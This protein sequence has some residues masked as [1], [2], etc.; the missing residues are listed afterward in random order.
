MLL[1]KASIG[2]KLLLAF[3]AMA[4]IVLMSASVGV[5]SFSYVAQTE[6]NVVNRVIPSMIEA[7]KVSELSARIIS[8]VQALTNSRTE[9]ERQQTGKTLFHQLETLLSH[10]SQLGTDV[11]DTSLLDKLAQD[12]QMIID[13]LA[14]L[15]TVVEGK[16]KHTA[17]IDDQIASMRLLATELE[18]LARTQ[19]LNTSTIAVA[20]ITHIYK[21]LDENR[22]DPVYHALDDLVEVDLDL[23]ERLHEFHLLAHKVLNQ[24]E[25]MPTVTDI[26]RI[27][28]IRV[29]FSNNLSIMQ[30]RVKAVEDPTRSVQMDILLQDLLEDKSVFNTL[31]KRFESDVSLE[32][33]IQK[34]MQQMVELN[35]TV[36]QL[37]DESNAS[38]A[39]AV[40]NVK[41]T[42]TKA[43]WTLAVLAFVG[44]LLAA[45]IVWRVVYQQVV[46][47]L[48]DYASA[49]RSIADGKLNVEVDTNGKD[50]LAEMGKA[51]VIARDTALAK[52]SAE[53]ANKAKSA[54]LATMSHEIRTP[55]NGV[56]GT[57]QLLQDTSL[58][59][60]QTEYLSVIERSGKTLLAILNDILDYS[61][62]EAGYLDIRSASFN[63]RSAV[64][65]V[66][67]LFSASAQEKG[68]DINLCVESDVNTFWIG[69]KTRIIQVLSNLV[70]NAVKF[71][72]NGYIDIHVHMDSHSEQNI[73]NVTFEVTDSGIGISAEDKKFLFDAFTQ[74]S[75]N[76][77]SQGGT[78]LG[79]AICHRLVTAMGGTLSVESEKGNGSCFTVTIPLEGSD[80][81]DFSTIKGKDEDLQIEQ[82]N[83]HRLMPLRVLLVEDNLINCFVAEGFLKSLGHEVVVAHSGKE[84]RELFETKIEFNA[85][86]MVLMDINLPGCSGVE[87]L[88]EFKKSRSDMP[89]IAVSA[90][91]FNEE[92]ERYLAAGFDGY[93]AK[94]IDRVL[95]AETLS[96]FQKPT[97]HQRQILSEK[98]QPKKVSDE[99]FVEQTAAVERNFQ[100]IDEAVLL[101]DIK[102]LGLP[103]AKKMVALF[104]SGCIEA[105]VQLDQSAKED[106]STEIKSIAHKL[107]GSASSLGLTALYNTCL[108]IEKSPDPNIEYHKL[109]DVLREQIGLSESALEGLIE[110]ASS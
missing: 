58:N 100:I 17:V 4:L 26:N 105:Q 64:N 5:L 20:N 38:T 28:Q 97:N 108:N 103:T 33:L 35:N 6:R 90:H 75:Q 53:Q 81:E 83:K 110:K 101:A 95:L 18:E 3:S 23:S 49:L 65:D 30:R 102:V 62:I 74:A 91:V 55:M 60:A 56:L 27:E 66:V 44:F 25:E 92:V 80:A 40:D 69:D 32:Q 96:L 88:T 52:D 7:R 10:I 11:F 104:T 107:K 42:L 89:M 8:S 48:D 34:N 78:G 99:V 31:Q 37:V 76:D 94:P 77:Q 57:V 87:L 63:L 68:L 85:L 86:D 72:E 43:Q 46:I 79:L 45:L 54:F 24:I 70:G 36:N 59:N 2:R 21:L 51:I 14:E 12:V 84:A 50:E 82:V 29:E 61:K 106:N 47:R 71:T 15:G 1:A 109:K 39:I 9:L 93:L 19:V 13:T 67:H 41:S 73:S 16:L 22:L 98:E